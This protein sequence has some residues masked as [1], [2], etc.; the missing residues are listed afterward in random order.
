[1]ERRLASS[2][3]RRA[4]PGARL[5]CEADIEG[6]PG[7]RVWLRRTSREADF[8]GGQRNSGV[9]GRTSQSPTDEARHL[10]QRLAL[11]FRSYR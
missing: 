3:A 11:Q 4:S 10:S 9:G 2:F 6:L 1:V 8:E 7:S 5:A